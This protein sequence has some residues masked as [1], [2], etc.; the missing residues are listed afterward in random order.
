[1]TASKIMES[2]KRKN[3]VKRQA[4]TKEMDE[5]WSFKS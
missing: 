1:M 3:Q 2:K 4:D 5:I